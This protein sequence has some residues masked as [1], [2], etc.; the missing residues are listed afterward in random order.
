VTSSSFQA[1]WNASTGATDYYL[2]VSTSSTFSTYVFNNYNVGNY[3]AITVTPLSAG[4]TYYYRVRAYNSSGTSGNSGTITVATLSASPAAPVATAATSVTSSSFQANWN[5]STGA[6]DYYLDVSTS[7]TFSSYVYNNYEVGNY[8]GIT[9]NGLSAGTTYYYRVR[10]Y[11]SSGTSGNSGTITVAT[12][13]AAPAA[14]V[15]TAA[16]SVTSSSF[17][18]NWNAST[19]ATDY[20]IDVST[21]STFSTYVIDNYEVGNY[22]GITFTGLSPGTTY[23]Y[24]VRAYNSS[25]TSGNSSTISVT[26]TASPPSAPTASA[27]TSVTS[28]G[29]TANWNSVTGAT[30]YRLDVST[31][32][33]FSSYVSGYQN[34]DLGNVLSRSVSGLSASTTYYYQVRAY[35]AGGTSGNSLTVGVT[36]IAPILTIAHSGKSVVISWPSPSTGF[37]LQQNT[38]LA[39]AAGW[40]SF[41]GTVSDNG[42]TKSV[43]NSPPIGNCFFRLVHP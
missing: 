2:D 18:A 15:A 33:T 20:Y 29:F 37:V 35:N 28:S 5:A 39:N 27:A 25:G 30:G 36:T 4:T 42:V 1:N 23:Y 24:R 8:I 26:T 21:S 43:T 14:P 40:S 13:S 34:L 22:I 10:A 32:S 9:V 38:N 12:L 17:Q 6:T 41:G 16:T 11:N 19:G 3:T 7:S 31:S